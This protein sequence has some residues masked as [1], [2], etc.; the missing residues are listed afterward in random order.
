MPASNQTAVLRRR[1]PVFRSGAGVPLPSSSPYGRGRRSTRRITASRYRG[2]Y[3]HTAVV[4]DGYRATC[5][6]SLESRFTSVTTA[7]ED[8]LV[9]DGNVAKSRGPGTALELALALV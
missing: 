4:L 8:R 9:V 2:V 5:Y 1:S 7:V 3:V 6:P